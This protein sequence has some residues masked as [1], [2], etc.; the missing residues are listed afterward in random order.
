MRGR[1][2]GSWES[3]RADGSMGGGLMGVWGR[4]CG[5]GRRADGRV[6]GGLRESGR[7]ADGR[8]GGGLMGEWGEG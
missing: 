7:R 4:V 6:G 2:E 5:E 8:V 3:G 1:E